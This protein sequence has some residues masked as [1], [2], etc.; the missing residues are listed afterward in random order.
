PFVRQ[1]CELK[2]NDRWKSY[3]SRLRRFYYKP[4]I[5]TPRRFA[6]SHP[7]V[8]QAQW[9]SLVAEWDKKPNQERA[10]TYANNRKELRSSHTNG[11]KNFC[12]DAI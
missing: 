4:N 7:I 2:L 9:R 11:T 3:K 6:C 10:L 12:T 1:V 5:G 8:N